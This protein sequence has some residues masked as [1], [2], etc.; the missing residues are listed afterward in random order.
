MER[1][2]EK[3]A[4]DGLN[5]E[6]RFLVGQMAAIDAEQAQAWSARH[7]NRYDD[8]I[9]RKRAELLAETDAAAAIRE[10]TEK[11]DNLTPY[12]LQDLAE[13]LVESAPDRAALFAEEAA[14]RVLGFN[15]SD[16]ATALARAG[17]VLFR[18]GRHDAGRKLIE[19]AAR[20]AGGLKDDD[21]SSFARGVAA[22]AMAPLDL[23]RALALIE[24][25]KE[26]RGRDRY[27]GFL[28][29]AIGGSNPD[30]ALALLETLEANTSLPQTLTTG[31]A[32]AIAPTQ[33]DR[34]VRLVE[35]M[36]GYNPEKYQ[37]EAFGWL[38][39]AIAPKDKARAFALVDRALALPHRQAGAVRELHLLR[40]G[41]RLLGGHRAQRAADRLSRHGERDDAGHGGA[42][43]RAARLQRPGDA[44]P[45]HDHRRAPGGLAR[46]GRR[47]HRAGTGRG[48]KRALRHRPGKRR[49]RVVAGRL[50]PGGPETRRGDRGGPDRGGEDPGAPG[51]S[52]PRPAQDDRGAAHPAPPPRGGTPSPDR[53]VVA[54]GLFHVGLR[55][56][57]GSA[58]GTQVRRI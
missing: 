18:A 41:A 31:I 30:R 44:G 51:S 8:V 22:K 7:D 48:A 25:I 34:A 55:V 35:G 23:D 42:A 20:I 27:T 29:D 56:A 13:R 33:P 17:S 26:R 28:I 3:F 6:G 21:R 40:R 53:C 47:G 10:L 12:T 58:T 1:L 54:A 32:F 49:R 4:N 37:A 9:R 14:K 15:E 38:A 19:E 5:D 36:K 50:E 11:A 39:L 2:W 46:P 16:R 24:P 57:F 52:P 43:G 45:G